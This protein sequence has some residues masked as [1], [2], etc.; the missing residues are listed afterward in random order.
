MTPKERL[1][2]RQGGVPGPMGLPTTGKTWKEKD[3]S[4]S[5]PLLSS[6]GGWESTAWREVQKPQG[7]DPDCWN[8]PWRPAAPVPRQS[9]VTLALLGHL[10][11][12]ASGCCSS[13]SSEN[14]NTEEE[15]KS[16]PC[17]PCPHTPNSAAIMSSRT[18]SMGSAIRLCKI[19]TLLPLY[20]PF[21]PLARTRKRARVLTQEPPGHEVMERY[22]KICSCT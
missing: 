16:L 14:H 13:Q 4:F 11:S 8:I 6:H 22:K 15:S 1:D 5:R 7:R 10:S 3:L 9:T 19:A 17:A 21:C 18:S 12:P 20:I 2:H